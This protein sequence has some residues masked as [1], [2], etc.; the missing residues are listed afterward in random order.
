M[1]KLLRTL[2]L[3][4]LPILPATAALFKT[5]EFVLDNGLQVVVIE[6]HKA[7]LIK[8]MVWYKA[9]AVDEIRG[10]GGIAHL[11]EHLMFRGTLKNKDGEFNRLMDTLGAESNAFTGHNVTA[12]HEFADVSTLE[13]LMAAEADRMHELA[14]DQKAFDTEQKV[15]FQERQQVVENNPAAPFNERMNLLLWG[16]S[17]YGQPV[18]GQNDEI[19]ALSYED[20]RDF[21]ALYYAPN[22]AILVLSGDI[23]PDLARQLAEKYYGKLPTSDVKRTVPAEVTEHYTA[24][25]EMALPNIQAVKTEQAFLLPNYQTLKET[26]YDYAVLA[27]YL[28]G[29]ETSALYKDLV[30]KQQKVVGV[31]ADY[32]YVTRGNSVFRLVSLPRADEEFDK[33]QNA[34]L[35]Q[36]AMAQAMQNLTVGELEKVKRKMTA[37]LVYLNDNPEDAAYLVG[38]MLANGFSLT[39]V[40]NIQKVTLEGV[41]KAYH[42]LLQ[43]SSVY[44]VLLPEKMKGAAQ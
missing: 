6:N 19:M 9:G 43:A 33:A 20:A 39:D 24:T 42:H 23:E 32:H 31:A 37:D 3:C 28:G 12:Y 25:L 10:K 5:S 2:I 11:L 17:P 4:M 22:N 36:E 34:V 1:K 30:L 8:H 27:E 35:L 26:M 15:V 7:P 14:F 21:Y 40:E 16:I 38:S 41:Q 13:A 29:G 18:T 44:G